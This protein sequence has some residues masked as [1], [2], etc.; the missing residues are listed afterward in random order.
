MAAKSLKYG[1]DARAAIQS[2][3]NK[4][5]DALRVT[6]GPR[7]RTVGID[8]KF[9]GPTLVDDGVTIAKEI[10][11]EDRFEN[12]GALLIREVSSRT[13]DQ[14]GDGT[15]TS[16][17]LAQA[18]LNE[19]MR[20][21]TSGSNPIALK[22]GIDKAA[23]AVVEELKKQSRK[24]KGVED[25]IKVATISS[26]NDDIGQ[27]VGE[28]V[29]KV[30]LDGVVTVEEGK[31]MET[32]VEE[33]EGLRFDKGY[34]SPYFVTNATSMEVV[35]EDP[36]ILFYEKKISNVPDLLPF[37]EKA[38]QTGRPVIIIA[39][40]VESEPLAM[41]VLNRIRGGFRCAAIKAPGFGDRR[42]AML[43]DMAI[44][45]GGKVVS[46]ELGMTLENVAMDMLGS[47]Q[48]IVVTREHTTI[49]GGKGKKSDIDGRIKQIKQQIEK[50][51][52]N[53]DKEKLSERLAKLVGGVTV[54]KVGAVTESEMKE[55][56][57][58]ITD[59][60]N[61]TR[62]ALEE[63]IVSGGGLALLR[64]SNAIDKVNLH[65]DEA[66]GATILKRAL[67]A[68]LRTIAD[69]SGVEGSAIVE[70]V[71]KQ[72]G[73]VGFDAGQLKIHDLMAAGIID[74]TKVV[75]LCLQNAAS[76][77]GL[78]LTTE[79]A[80]ADVQEDDVPHTPPAY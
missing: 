59:A 35:Y 64:A 24:L 9:G 80:V 1:M 45:T 22:R 69:N 66:I 77:A 44:L 41:L 58:R 63:G 78:L 39:E 36:L 73:T 38:A 31:S 2:G 14:A 54:I 49:V 72:S 34:I 21:V 7:G 67:A 20:S 27:K 16:A 79:A 51:T 50:A 52:S 26:K 19:G 46:E 17:I 13:N 65:G 3:V 5:A 18:I 43:E 40:D 47:C 76:I 28:A 11:L 68:P 55:R 25:A 48:R 56:K 6:L 70:R 10:E 61:A 8:K 60:L 29:Y 74:P 12:M 30:G 71:R 32:I 75:R 4:M 57:E 62:A 23:D 53:Y 37:L 15:T 42:K 33:V